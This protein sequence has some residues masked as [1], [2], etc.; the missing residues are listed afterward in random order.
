MHCESLRFYWFGDKDGVGSIKRRQRMRKLLLIMGSVLFLAAC[1]DKGA[2]NNGDGKISEKEASAEMAKGGATAMKP[3]LWEIKVS[4]ADF[5]APGVPTA[6]LA[7]M[8]SN[9]EK[10]VTTQSCMT[11][12]QVEKPDANFFGGRQEG[13]CVYNKLDRSGNTMSVA[14]TCKPGGK[15]VSIVTMDGTFAAES[16]TMKM[17]QKVDG[18]PMGAMEILGAIEGKRLG[19]CPQ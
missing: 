10:G 14:M 2:D 4:V 3:G 18:T 5:V 6:S 17:T 7:T 13:G 19:D 16:Y 1:S 11:K 9:A 12:D 8:K 15:M